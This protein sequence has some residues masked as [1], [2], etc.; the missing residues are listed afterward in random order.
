MPDGSSEQWIE[1]RRL[2]LAEIARLNER[3]EVITREIKELEVK[4]A[5]LQV[6]AGA[7]GLIGGAVPAVVVIALKYL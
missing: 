5:V 6:K 7:L 2:L 3:Q 1:Y 4:L